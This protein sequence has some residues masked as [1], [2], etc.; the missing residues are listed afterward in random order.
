[1]QDSERNALVQE[2]SAKFGELVK[3]FAEHIA[4]LE[5]A[6]VT[7][8]ENARTAAETAVNSAV[9]AVKTE[10][11][12]LVAK[13][14]GALAPINTERERERTALVQALSTHSNTKAVFSAADLEAKPLDELRKIAQVSMVVVANYAGRG[15]PRSESNAPTLEP[16]FM[17]PRPYFEKTTSTAPEAK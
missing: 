11:A 16:R 7:T 15:A 10:L 2:L 6:A 5:A 14:D 1:M 4:R 13:V 9:S 12:A 17:A 3:P 8:A